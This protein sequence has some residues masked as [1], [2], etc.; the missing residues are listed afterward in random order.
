MLFDRRVS[1]Q[2][3]GRK[4][5]FSTGKPDTLREAGVPRRGLGE[6]EWRRVTLR[7]ETPLLASHSLFLPL[8]SFFFLCLSSLWL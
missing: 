3:R 5:L 2:S 7:H 4:G 1:V 6:H 8:I